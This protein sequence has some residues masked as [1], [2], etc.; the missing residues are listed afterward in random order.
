MV[1]RRATSI[2]SGI[3]KGGGGAWKSRL[4]WALKWLNASLGAISEP[5]K[6]KHTYGTEMI[7][8]YAPDPCS[9]S[10]LAL[11]HSPDQSPT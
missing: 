11:T 3:G 6:V 8:I 7:R 4:F 10:K 1:L 9:K 2:T 5:K